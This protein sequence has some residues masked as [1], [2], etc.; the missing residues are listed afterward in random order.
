MRA[1]PL[2][3]ALTLQLAVPLRSYAPPR[4]LPPLQCNERVEIPAVPNVMEAKWSPDSKT[5]ALVWFTQLPSKRSVTGYVEQEIVD[6][7]DVTTGRL[8]PVGVGDEADWS[9]TG[10]FISYWS[11]GGEELRVARDGRIVARLL[12]TIPRIHWAGDGLVFIEKDEIRE[13][14]DGA[15]RTIAKLD[16][17]YRPKYP[18]DDVYF[19]G[20]GEHFTLTRY[21]QDGTLERYLGTTRTGA[22]EPLDA[23]GAR[24]LEWAPAGGA[25][26]VRYLDRI[27]LRDPEQGTKSVSLAG[28]AATV[29]EWAPDGRTLLLGRVSPTIPGGDAFDGFRVWPAT[30]GPFSANLPNLLG[31]RAFSPDGKYFAGV[32]RSGAQTTRL[33]VW[34]CGDGSTPAAAAPDAAAR[35]GAIDAGPGRLVRPTAG[36][37]SQ[38]LQGSH[39]GIDVATP[40]GSIITADDDGVVDAVGF[41]AVGGN[42]VC[43]LHA[44]ALESCVYHTSAPLVGIGERVVRGQPIALIGM[45]GV[46][47]GP[48]THWEVKQAGRIVD[49]LGR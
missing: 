29:H 6:T 36:E 39:T 12:P 17:A 31:A 40:F 10:A 47:T 28:A 43:V 9:A 26:L 3:L 8:W 38:F 16:P 33:E 37:I 22:I 46:T 27:E 25:L 7:F 4:E 32:S 1:V 34:R 30:G 48:H 45:T 24:F 15:V 35:L 41:V 20:D 14:R 19:S 5:L 13:W 21:S 2:L 23:T 44:G 18:R 49:P 42:R 11:P